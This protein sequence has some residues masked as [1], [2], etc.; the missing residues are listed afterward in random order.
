MGEFSVDTSKWEHVS[1][2]PGRLDAEWEVH[3]D[4]KM[5][6]VVRGRAATGILHEGARK[7]ANLTSA[8]ADSP[9]IEWAYLEAQIAAAVADKSQVIVVQ[10]PH[11][12]SFDVK[13]LAGL[14]LDLGPYSGVVRWA[15]VAVPEDMQRPLDGPMRMLVIE[16]ADWRLAVMPMSDRGYP[17]LLP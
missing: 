10:R 9:S 5:M 7:I 15:L 16:S 12:E 13:R 11:Q 1:F 8:P 14:A 17:A 3:T 6:L 4:G 2:S